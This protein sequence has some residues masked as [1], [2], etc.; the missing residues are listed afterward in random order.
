M[1][2][3]VAYVLW[4]AA[5]L[6]VYSYVVYPA[7][8]LVIA[9]C[10][11]ARSH[12]RVRDEDLPSV[13]VVVAAYNEQ[14]HIRA[15]IENLLAQDYPRDR[16]HILV[17]SDGSTDDTASIAASVRDARVQLEA[18]PVNRGKASVLNDLL[19]RATAEVIVFTDAN[20]EFRPDTVRA[21]ASEIVAG[22]DVACGELLLYGKDGGNADSAYWTLE[23]QLKRAEAAFGGLLGANGA[24][25]AMRRTD[26]RPISP[27]TICDD[28]VIAM[29][30]AAAGKRSVY[31]TRAVALEQVPADVASEYTRRV[32]IGIGN[33]Q[34][35]F[36]HPEYLI[37]APL[38]LRM[39]YVS[40]KVLRWLTP[41]MLLVI[42]GCSSLL[43]AADIGFYRWLAMGELAACGGI[44]L[45]YASRSRM[46]WPRVVRLPMLFAVLN[47]AFLVA[48]VRYICGDF[49][50]SWTR[51]E[52]EE[53]T[54]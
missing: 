32:R 4:S 47:V 28:F 10:A 30:A 12:P 44:A 20:T 18:F 43:G 13:A 24:V 52:R 50:G 17:G 33:Y 3:A 25:Y 36:R 7:A 49:R 38:A 27:D 40:H 21:L 31:A 53:A 41:H 35:L 39:S 29:S 54:T 19:A 23:R 6:L 26:Y 48:F 16:L 37:R 1:M 9:A 8:L 51:T 42:L 15:R 14:A 5:G 34:A 11:R 46:P 22:A 2:T 45:A